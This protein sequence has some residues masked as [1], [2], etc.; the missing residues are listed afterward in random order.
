MI[1]PLF[2]DNDDKKKPQKQG[3]EYV[4]PNRHGRTIQP[5][6]KDIRAD[7]GHHTP[8]H[9]VIPP[10]HHSTPQAQ[11]PAP[12]VTHHTPS[13]PPARN[14]LDTDDKKVH[15]GGEAKHREAP[16]H[17]AG[18]SKSANP[19]VELIRRKLENLYTTE[20]N[21]NQEMAEVTATPAIATPQRS[22][23]Q[24]FMYDLS[25]SGKSLAQIQTEWHNYYL[26]LPDDEKHQVWQEFYTNNGKGTS[27]GAAQPVP[28]P[29]P[30]ANPQPATAIHPVT[31]LETIAP[32]EPE[33]PTEPTKPPTNPIESMI[34]VADHAQKPQEAEKKEEPKKPKSVAS[35][36][37]GKSAQALK[38]QVLKR[39]NMSAAQQA[40]AAQHFKSLLFGISS[41]TIVLAVV[42]FGL[43]N[44]MIIAPLIQPSS[45]ASATPIILD[46]DAVAPSSTP[47]IIIPKINV[48]IPVDYSLTTNDESAVE[49]ALE[50]GIVHYPST[51]K[52]GE[53]GNAAFFGHSSNNIFNPG[54]YKFAFVLLHELVPG[55]IFYITYS[56]KVYT[57]RVYAKQI[58]KP[59]QVEVLNNVEGKLATATLIT[60]D[61]PGTSLNRLVVWGEQISPDPSG[62][63]AP[64]TSTDTGTTTAGQPTKITGNGPTLWKRLTS[65]ITGN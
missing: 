38:K 14:E 17:K 16:K 23:H 5:I 49:S 53:Q 22:K 63:T 57:Y 56:G 32:T 55:D 33:K 54:K 43:F 46:T 8:A 29:A 37:A 41:A 24:Q 61:P 45:H 44:E 9:P 62:A 60:C 11:T 52:P 42:L 21:A 20:P 12:A 47:E 1:S 10:Q 50:N 19:A 25:T 28:Q 18:H 26:A 31:G 35:K 51:V 36:A 30:I 48:E 3:S 39:V 4:L 7:E 64:T 13:L 15:V 2:D 40:K 34:V 6:S 65:W 27:F 58:V 59:S